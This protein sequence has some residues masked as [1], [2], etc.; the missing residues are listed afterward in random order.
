MQIHVMHIECM[1]CDTDC[2]LSV[3]I[4]N[5]HKDVGYKWIIA[6]VHLEK[7]LSNALSS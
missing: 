6:R 1:Q 7:N 2:A 3:T 5:G 4:R